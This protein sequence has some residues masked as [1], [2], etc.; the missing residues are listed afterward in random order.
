MSDIA[1]LRGE[2]EGMGSLLSV[3]SYVENLVEL[4]INVVEAG[5][6]AGFTY[7]VRSSMMKASET[8]I[9]LPLAS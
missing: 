1:P 7:V 6:R 4:G 8:E 5:K 2:F 3:T 9:T